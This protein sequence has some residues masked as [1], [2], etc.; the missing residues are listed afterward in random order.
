MH[1]QRAGL[2]C[3]QQDAE[4]AQEEHSSEMKA[5]LSRVLIANTSVYY[6]PGPIPST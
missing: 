4:P 3:A 2:G 1:V 6:M 5:E